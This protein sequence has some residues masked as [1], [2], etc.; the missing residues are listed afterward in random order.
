MA[1][2]KPNPFVYF[3]ESIVEGK[4]GGCLVNGLVV[5]MVG[6]VLLLPPISLGDRLLSI[7]YTRIGVQGGSIEEQGLEINFLP[8]G[9]TRAFRVSLDAIPRSSFL[10]GSAGNSLINAAESIPPNLVMRSPYYEINQRGAEPEAV[11]LV[12]PLPGEV[13][14]IN[15]LDLYAW[16]GDDWEW[17][18]NTKIP[19][20]D[21]IESQLDYLPESIV[22]MATHPINPNVSTN[23]TAGTDLPD[24]VR[25]TLVE[26]N[27][28][29]LF[30][31]NDGRVG[32]TLDELSPEVQNS[33]LL[34]VPTIRNWSDDGVVRTDLIDNMLI[35]EALMERHVES[36]VDVVE[37]NAYQGI[38]IDYRAIS[39]ELRGEFTTFIEQ[40]GQALPEN[41]V[42]SVR[43]DPVRQISP[44]EWETGAYDWQ[45]IG[46]V[47]DVVKIPTFPDPRAY[48]QGGEMETMLNW[49]VGNV[50]RYKI[51]LILSTLSTEQVNGSQHTINYQE[52]LAPI[53]NVAVMGEN[54]VFNPG[55]QLGF[56]LGGLSASTGIQFDRDSGA[57]WYAYLD[58]Q[59][60][61]RT[62]YLENA[63]SIARKL[64][65]VA[66]YNLRGVAM[67]N[68][69]NQS[70]DAQVWSVMSQFLDLVIPPVE[71]KYSVV[72]RVQ[73][74]DGGVIAEEIVDLSSP[75]Y[76]W[77]A[78]EGGGAYQVAASIASDRDT[79]AAVPRGNVA[80][81]V[82]TPT[83][84]PSPTPLPSPTPEVEPTEELPPAPV[85]VAPPAPVEEEAPPPAEEPP[86]ADTGVAAV[87]PAQGNL[88]FAYGIQADPR[89][90]TTANISLIKGMGF[91]WVKFQMAW[92]DVE[93][94]PGDYGWGEWDSVINSYSSSG[95]KVLLSIPK[96]PDWARPPDDDRSVEGPPQ[97]PNT[98]AT[99]VGAVAGRY[100]GKVQAIEVWNEQNL[101]YEAG[102]QGRINPA[103]YTE[104]LK[105][106]YNAIK[107]ANPD[108]IVVTGAM[109]PTGAP[110]PAA[111]DDVE[112]LRQMYAN[113]AKG[114]FDAV[115]AHPS[116]FAN[117][118]DALYQGGD[119]DPA[120]GYDDHRS[121]FFRNTMEEYRRVM[122]ENGDGDKTIWPTEFGWP[123]WRFTGDARFTFA[124]QNSLEQQANYTVQA[125]QLGKEWGWVGTMFLWNLDYNVTAGNTEL[126]NFGI[127]GTP[128]YDALAA[129]PK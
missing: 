31:D 90:N 80:I 37:R 27:P 53:G 10:E 75:S 93:G 9:V 91:N 102:G 118:P 129:M 96:A 22:V 55:Q 32:G 40:L 35:E 21:V 60:V 108:M 46:Q 92:K 126:A 26:I 24:N 16:N 61:Q 58:D 95:I 100:K 14:D 20:E 104:L 70:N 115:G 7:G 5:L 25:D 120:R 76:S 85:V 89:G 71:S 87:A 73:N 28:R 114:F 43:V 30:L 66:K 59:D 105:L 68:L 117:P 4:L 69:L 50:D 33:S 63:A 15:T 29:G 42:L 6:M 121:F 81:L 48:R 54:M 77:T 98:Y 51:Q 107:S 116:G 45:A 41:K 12:V 72:W 36:L 78:P 65:F 109:T 17:L 3:L 56:T 83:P 127:V 128:A 62:V 2:P 111:M 19:A 18:P 13:E 38:D 124:Q 99:F 106:S 52:A 39:P 11:L 34:V 79:S 97:D 84:E 125:Y 23:F 122:V 74:E 94:S 88:P 47:A 123:V 82:A 86:P 119:F 44:N 64:Q 112:Y 67:E 49:A 101:Y 113:G 57:Y 8:E 103:I 1:S 110:P